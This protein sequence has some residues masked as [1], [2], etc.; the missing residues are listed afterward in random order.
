MPLGRI[1]KGGIHGKRDRGRENGYRGAISD[2][3]GDK[4]FEITETK[5]GFLARK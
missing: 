3:Y 4:K 5:Y 1:F 2:N